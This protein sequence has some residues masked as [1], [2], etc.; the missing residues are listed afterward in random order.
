[1]HVC[2]G[3]CHYP[4]HYSISSRCNSLGFF[5]NWSVKQEFHLYTYG[6]NKNIHN[7]TYLNDIFNSTRRKRGNVTRSEWTLGIPTISTKMTRFLLYW[8]SGEW[9]FDRLPIKF[10]LIHK[11]EIRAEIFFMDTFCYNW[12]L[13]ATKC[14]NW[15]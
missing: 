4:C 11:S 6:I 7:L 8:L 3:K 5:F 14:Y 12:S 13:L 1:M 10:H 9:L 15:L 2:Y